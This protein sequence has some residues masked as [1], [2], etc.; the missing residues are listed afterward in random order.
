[1]LGNGDAHLKN[2][3]LLYTHPN[4]GD[5]TLSPAYDIVCTTCYIPEDSMALRMMGTQEFFR[6]RADMAEFGETVCGVP[7]ARQRL[8]ELA[9]IANA[10]FDRYAD[11]AQEVPRLRESLT[12]GIE[13]FANT[14]GND[15]GLRH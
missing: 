11:L 8:F 2:F 15:R 7:N 1:M 12:H 13:Q 4:A 9:E 10:V 6:A 14:Y 3:G 5:A